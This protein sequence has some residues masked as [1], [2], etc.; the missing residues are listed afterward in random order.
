MGHA[1]YV[2]Q[3]HIVWTISRTVSNQ[4]CLPPGFFLLHIVAKSLGVIIPL[5]LN[6]CIFQPENLQR[7][8]FVVFISLHLWSLEQYSVHSRDLIFIKLIY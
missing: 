5:N 8:D 1:V 7:G 3:G 6:L 2:S 4:V